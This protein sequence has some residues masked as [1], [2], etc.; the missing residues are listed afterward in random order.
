MRSAFQAWM[1]PGQSFRRFVAGG[2]CDDYG[3]PVNRSATAA[4]KSNDAV[5][6]EIRATT[7]SKLIYPGRCI[8]KQIAGGMFILAK[9]PWLNWLL[10]VFLVMAASL[11]EVAWAQEPLITDTEQVQLNSNEVEFRIQ[12]A[13]PLQYIN[14]TPETRGKDIQIQ[15][16]PLRGLAA[17]ASEFLED[18]SLV[19]GSSE[20]RQVEYEFDTTSGFVSIRIRLKSILNFRIQPSRDYR[21]IMLVIER[22]SVSGERDDSPMQAEALESESRAGTG[23][24][25]STIDEAGKGT[26]ESAIGGY[27]VNLQSTTEPPNL[28]DVELDAVF[29]RYTLHITEVILDGKLWHRLGLGF[30]ASYAEAVSAQ[31]A[32]KSRYPGA[33]ISRVTSAELA[34]LPKPVAPGAPSVIRAEKSRAKQEKESAKEAFLAAVPE[35]EIAALM[36]EARQAMAGNAYSRAVQLYTKVLRYPDHSYREAAQEFLGVARE[37]NKQL[38]HAKCEYEKYLVLYPE[39]EGAERV[40]QRLA[41]LVTAREA[42][43]PALKSGRGQKQEEGG[44]Q[45]R[46]YGSFSQFY[47]RDVLDIEPQGSKITQN[48]LSTDINV[49]ARGRSDVLDTNIRFTGG[50]L[51][52]FL[53]DDP[54]SYSHISSLY[55]DLNHKETGLSTRLGRQTRSTGGVLGRFDGGVFGYRMRDDIR[56]NLV[57]GYPVDRSSDG[58]DMDRQFWGASVDLG[59]YENAWDFVLFYIDQTNEDL[60]G[61]RAVGGELRYFTAERS[62]LGLVDYDI[63]FEKLN[64]ILLIGNMHLPGGLSLNAQ[65]DYRTSPFLTVQNAL[66][67]QM[68]TSLSELL[69]SFSE[70]EIYQLAKDRTAESTSFTLGASK[71][72][73]E[74]L[75]ISG[76]ITLTELSGTPAS[77][78]VLAVPGTGVDK[79]YNLQLIGSNLL[80][81]GDITVAGVR[82]S[83]TSN[84]NTAT[85]SLNTRYPITTFWRLNPRIRLDYKDRISNNSTEWVIIPSLR[86]DY[87]LQRKYYFEVEV[88]GEYSQLDGPGLSN[89]TSTYYLTAGY[90]IDF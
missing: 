2:S 75:Q 55:V 73:T 54:E 15:L 3:L 64:T 62:L 90:R 7:L 36:E 28:T 35:A 33:W 41:A 79:F 68:V 16:R 82:Y 71:P 70:D 8:G 88:G 22:P 19:P 39:G 10:A 60:T 11:S 51:K 32:L 49:S 1:A 80:K 27:V 58:V 46:T 86:M 43:R 59:T 72:L 77:G 87:L 57:A 26:A 23:R 40:R 38:A 52:D 76:D 4:M 21:Q 48:R 37:R 45:W 85:L 5:T 67:G 13:E 6:S 66:Q 83:D 14:H 17:L 69:S 56:F 20:V 74:K 78:G 89:T 12:F 53:D 84:V 30:F 34:G 18:Q 31:Q 29:N 47:R 42:P 44:T 25:T 50:Y 65:F 63:H 61:R 24:G 81:P 9:R